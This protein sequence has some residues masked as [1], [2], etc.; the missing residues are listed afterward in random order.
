[1]QKFWGLIDNEIK[2]L[3]QQ[4]KKNR[5]VRQNEFFAPEKNDDNY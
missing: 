2:T 5:S 3:S 4:F 1:M